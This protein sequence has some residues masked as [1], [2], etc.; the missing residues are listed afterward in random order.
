MHLPKGAALTLIF[1]ATTWV[2]GCGTSDEEASEEPTASR[3][4]NLGAPDIV[5]GCWTADQRIDQ[6]AEGADSVGHQQWN[7]A[8]AMVIDPAKQYTATVE[9]NKGSFEVAF[10]PNDAPKTVNNFVCLAR[11]GYYDDTPFH[12]IIPGFVIQGGDPTGSGSG[13]PG[14]RFEDETVSRDYTK[15]VLAMANSGP[16]TNG[17]QF[18]VVVGDLRGQLQKNYTIFGQVTSGEETVDAIA[19]TPIAPNPQTGEKSSPTV[20]VTLDRVTIQE[21]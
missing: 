6:G 1:L 9:T 14:Y 19:N 20:P 3:I 4:A 13:G 8:P 12:R 15:G 11:A 10:Y 5:S 7:E 21:R 18:F 17:S 2:A 16:N